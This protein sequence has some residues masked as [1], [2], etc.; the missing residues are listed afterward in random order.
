[1]NH[2]H[3]C[4]F[5]AQAT[6]EKDR[7]VEYPDKAEAESLRPFPLVIDPERLV[8]CDTECQ[9]KWHGLR[10]KALWG[11]HPPTCTCLGCLG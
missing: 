3:E 5:C 9:Q 8:F 7:V 10:R 1:V 2:L 4:E 11:S 6:I